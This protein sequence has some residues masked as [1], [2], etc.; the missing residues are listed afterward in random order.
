M[1]LAAQVAEGSSY[2]AVKQTHSVMDVRFEL[3]EEESLAR[4][5]ASGLRK[6][7]LAVTQ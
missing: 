4:K 7:L 3:L 2:R 5:V 1:G 6:I